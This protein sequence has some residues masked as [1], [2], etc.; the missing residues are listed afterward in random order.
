MEEE[1]GQRWLIPAVM[2]YDP[3]SNSVCAWKTW[4]GWDLALVPTWN[5]CHPVKRHR[6]RLPFF[7]LSKNSRWNLKSVPERKILQYRPRSEI[8]YKSVSFAYR[9]LDSDLCSWWHCKFP[10][11][12]PRVPRSEIRSAKKSQRPLVVYSIVIRIF[13]FWNFLFFTKIYRRYPFSF[14]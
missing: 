4:R 8:S 7:F 9:P 1:E 10:T 11:P 14:V 12:P 2:G 6:L 13:E 3:G 5:T